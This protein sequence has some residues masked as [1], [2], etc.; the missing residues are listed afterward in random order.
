MSAPFF[1][2]PALLA[3]D[4][5]T[6]GYEDAHAAHNLEPE[7]EAR[8]ELLRWLAEQVDPTV[9]LETVDA[10]ADFWQAMGVHSNDRNI[11][12]HRVP[13]TAPNR[14]R[15]RAAAL[16][17]LRAA[18]DLTLAIRR[19][20]PADNRP[21]WADAD[22]EEMEGEAEAEERGMLN[23]FDVTAMQQLDQLMAQRSV[24][25]PSA[26][27]LLADATSAKPK[28]QPLAPRAMVS[29]N[30]AAAT[31]VRRIRAGARR[32][33]LADAKPP[34]KH[35]GK[36]K[37]PGV[38]TREHV[39]ERLRALR[40]EMSDFKMLVA[41][42]KETAQTPPQSAA[43]DPSLLDCDADGTLVDEL[44]NTARDVTTRA[45][46]FDTIVDEATAVRHAH[47]RAINRDEAMEREISAQLPRCSRLLHDISGVLSSNAR[48]RH[49]TG[50]LR[51]SQ[52]VLQ[53]LPGC[54]VVRHAV[55][56]QARTEAH[57]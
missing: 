14:P 55:Q 41:R 40:L 49:A 29:T 46:Q 18:V 25:F 32:G 7:G 15:D 52:S 13:F 45:S 34:K 2:S 48:V 26:V 20:R 5:Q 50:Q 27:R 57:R 24:L 16:V 39:V 9:A 23:E 4:L 19:Q 38:P 56:Q 12:G 43:A 33:K 11:A 8:V 30:I 3:A 42:H 36:A 44:V 53:L 22:A 35:G 1:T 31:S 28:R 47:G 6:L 21:A 10:V 17:F 37:T 51:R 54:A